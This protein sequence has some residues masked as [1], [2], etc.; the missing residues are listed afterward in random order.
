MFEFNGHSAFIEPLL[1]YAERVERLTHDREQSVVTALMVGE[2]AG[3]ATNFTEVQEWFP[4][5]LLGVLGFATGAEVG[6]QWLDICDEAGAVVRRFD[7]SFG[8][9]RFSA[10]HAPIRE[11]IHTGI[12]YLL[13]RSL[14]SSDRHSSALR[15]AVDNV[16][17]AGLYDSGTVEEKLVYLFR[18][19]DGLCSEFDLYKG[20]T[21]DEALDPVRA[22][23]VLKALEAAKR[24]IGEPAV[25]AGRQCQDG[26]AEY[27]RRIAQKMSSVHIV[28]PGFGKAFLRL[29]EKFQLHDAQVM[30]GYY[31]NGSGWLQRLGR[32]RA[33]P[34]HRNYF[35]FLAG[36][37][38]IRDVERAI[39]HLHDILTRIVLKRLNYD[40]TYQPMV[41]KV[42]VDV[43]PDW[44]RADTAPA[45][46][47][48]PG[49]AIRRD[50]P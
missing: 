8:R 36:D 44:V 50:V 30:E 12:G 4:A 42:L 3:A 7:V 40:G 35:D 49:V 16:V 2:V 24:A 14:A 10:G 19:L 27:L 21:P 5:D 29:L 9:P 13:T 26:Q 32:F 31:G 15:T 43:Q 47:G 1:D 28:R 45:R 46:L 23:A 22:A 33:I 38:D 41:A 11:G 17:R 48:Y 34:V 37:D 18:G 20:V 39:F 6:A 25:D